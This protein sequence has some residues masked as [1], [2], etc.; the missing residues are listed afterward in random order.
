[1]TPENFWAN[2]AKCD[3]SE[4]SCWLWIGASPNGRYGQVV[5]GGRRQLAHR[6][7]YELVK[8]PIPDGL[9][10]DH[11][12]RMPRCVNPAHLEAVTFKENVLRGEGV[13]AKA[14]RQTHCVNGHPFAGTNLRMDRT[15]GQRICVTC[16]RK[17]G[18]AW[19]YRNRRASGPRTQS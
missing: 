7:A 19:Y 1:M 6:V 18:L 4:D 3:G 8:G 15:T 14:A 17:V 11:L 13:G 12:C 10:I 16:R 9:T 2:V 5:L